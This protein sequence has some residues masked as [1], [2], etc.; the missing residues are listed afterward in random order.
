MPGVVR[1]AP[2]GFAQERLVEPHGEPT[3]R[4]LDWK[5]AAQFCL[6]PLI[7]H[8]KETCP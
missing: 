3:Q 1:G 4:L 5:L 7:H 8:Q 6:N 2:L